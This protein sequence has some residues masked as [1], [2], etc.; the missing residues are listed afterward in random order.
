MSG[1]WVY[2]LVDYL[3]TREGV[4]VE[5]MMYQETDIQNCSVTSISLSTSNS[6][7]LGQVHT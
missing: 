1:F 2:N 3:D 7:G 5:A 6:F 4:P